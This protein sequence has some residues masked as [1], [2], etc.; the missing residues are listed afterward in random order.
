VINVEYLPAGASRPMTT[1]KM[2]PNSLIS[3]IVIHLIDGWD[4]HHITNPDGGEE[5]W[6]LALHPTTGEAWQWW[7]DGSHDSG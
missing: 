2:G 6:M 1:F 7:S 5:G 4:L 3:L